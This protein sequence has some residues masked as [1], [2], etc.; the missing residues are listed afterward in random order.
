MIFKLLKKYI[1]K[2]KIKVSILILSILFVA[3]SSLLPAQVLR[4]VIDE[5]EYSSTKKILLIAITYALTYILIGLCKFFKDVILVYFSQDFLTQLKKKMMTHY[6]KIKYH[7][8]TD[9]SEG[10][11]ESLF[12]NDV[13]SLDELFTSGAVDMLTDLIKIVGILISL[14]IYCVMIGFFV[15]ISLPIVILLTY[16]IK[17]GMLKAQLKTKSLES[18]SNSV[19]LESVLNIE[20]I[21]INHA[22]DY[23]IDKYNDNLISHY[24]AS[25]KS[26]FYDSI[27]SPLI[28]IVRSVLIC[29][30]LLLCGRKSDIFLVSIGVVISSITLISDL[31]SPISTIGMEIQT[32]QKSIASLKRINKFF[33]LEEIEEKSKIEPNDYN[34]TINNC[35]FSYEEE[36]VISK[37]SLD[38][39]ENERIILKGPSGSGKSTLMKLMMG[40][41]KP[42]SGNCLIG[43]AS[44]YLIDDSIKNELFSIVY[45]TPF[46]SGGS[47]YEEISLLDKNI[48]KDKVYEVLKEV[49]LDYIKD[50]DIILDEGSYSSGELQLFSLARAFV[51]DFKILFLD[52]MNSNIDPI[53]SKYMI[54]LIDKLCFNKTI[55]SINH[56]D[57]TL[58][59]AKIINIRDLK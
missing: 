15:T 52:E 31:F 12:N 51:K 41:L 3:L 38:I 32:I 28:E 4:I 49:G 24:N 19:L 36:Q 39:K 11:Y 47:I 48:T 14:Y 23:I 54:S 20:D 56:Y 37:Y 9:I 10:K 46:F 58:K 22:Y 33:L 30:I 57:D 40:L 26:N 6:S 2:H 8:L 21:K 53:T 1:L 55:I 44:S 16:L 5:Y 42:T 17:K 25:L 7:Y 18:N 27:F 59:N 34:M 50:I 35:S 43:D 45:Q 13:N 29:I